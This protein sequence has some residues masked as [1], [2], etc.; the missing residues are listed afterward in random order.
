MTT[1]QALVRMGRG[2]REVIFEMPIEDDTGE[3]Q[4]VALKLV[5]GPRD[6]GEPVITVMKSDED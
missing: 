2:E 6:L 4:S 1:I 3:C 5:C